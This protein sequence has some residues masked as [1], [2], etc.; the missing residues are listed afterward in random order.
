M[1][2][3]DESDDPR[4]N[5]EY[6]LAI[7]VL[8]LPKE[9]KSESAGE[10]AFHLDLKFPDEVNAVTV[11]DAI[12]SV[13]RDFH[14]AQSD[15]RLFVHDSPPYM[16]AAAERFKS[17]KGYSNC[18]HLPCWPHLFAKVPEVVFDSGCLAE[19]KEFHRLVQLLFA[20]SPYWRTKWYKFQNAAMEQ[21]NKVHE[22]LKGDAKERH[23]REK[24]MPVKSVLRST[25]VRW[26]ALYLAYMYW[27]GRFVPFKQFLLDMVKAL[28]DTPETVG[29]LLALLTDNN[30]KVIKT[31]LAFVAH[32]MQPIYDLIASFQKQTGGPANPLKC[33][34]DIKKNLGAAAGGKFDRPVQRL[35]DSLSAAQAR[36][37]AAQLQEASQM[38]CNTVDNLYKK[39]IKSQAKTQKA[40]DCF[41]PDA[42]QTPAMLSHSEVSKEIPEIPRT[43]WERYI[44]LPAPS[45]LPE[46]TSARVA[47][48]E[49]KAADFPILSSIAVFFCP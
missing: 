15:V 14:V 2:F 17:V 38:M 42:L 34:D 5:E 36:T 32:Y 39:T 19:V 13:C 35:L 20:R 23:E 22:Q 10:L 41:N 8:L 24:P 12:N 18:V 25:D 3:A 21:W 44:V 26:A 40:I 37:V 49:V 29:K 27:K 16:V 1:I 4:T 7:N 33:L 47:W 6:Q 43:E 9:F 31:Q 45:P 11:S 46:T 28:D 30:M 48:W